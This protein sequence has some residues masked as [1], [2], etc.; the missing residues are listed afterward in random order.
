MPPHATAIELDA[1]TQWLCWLLMAI[2]V[3]LGFFPGR[4]LALLEMVV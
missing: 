3:A 4:L 2:I 1:A